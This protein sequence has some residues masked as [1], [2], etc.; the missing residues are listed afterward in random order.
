[1]AKTGK[2]SKKGE[3][4]ETPLT[5]LALENA[6]RELMALGWGEEHWNLL[7]KSSRILFHHTP[8]ALPC[9]CRKCA[10]SET[11]AEDDGLV[12][13]RDVVVFDKF[14]LPFWA[15]EEL[16]ADHD[17]ETIRRS[18]RE[19]LTARARLLKRRSRRQINLYSGGSI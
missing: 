12:Y 18:M 3:K 5:G 6:A 1:M 8:G 15:P 16:F 13:R 4:K 11:T 2:K 9:L 17:G 14:S 10:I 7:K 19:A